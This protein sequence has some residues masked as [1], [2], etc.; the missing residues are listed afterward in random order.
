MINEAFIK[1]HGMPNDPVINNRVHRTTSRYW[2][3][4]REIRIAIFQEKA[5]WKFC[6]NPSI[7]NK[8][9]WIRLSERFKKHLT[10]LCPILLSLLNPK[11]YYCQRSFKIE[12]FSVVK[13]EPPS[14]KF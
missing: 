3:Y 10:N 13:I 12:P 9:V 14:F 11:T 8:L 6:E 4:T 5:P 7:V 1:C 2:A